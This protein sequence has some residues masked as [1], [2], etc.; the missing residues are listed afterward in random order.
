MTSRGKRA[1]AVLSAMG[2]AV[3]GCAPSIVPTVKADIDRR[4]AALGPQAK[5]FDARGGMMEGARRSSLTR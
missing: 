3:G 2:F 1:V 5:S 4:F